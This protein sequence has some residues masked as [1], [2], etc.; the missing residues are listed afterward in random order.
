MIIEGYGIKIKDYGIYAD[1]HFGIEYV[2]ASQGIQIP[3]LQL[4]EIISRVSNSTAKKLI[5]AGDIKHE[6]G[7]ENPLEK[8]NVSKFIENMQE[9]FSEII[10][11]RGNHDNFVYY[12]LK[13]WGVDLIEYLEIDDTLIIHGH[14][15]PK[16]I[17]LKS[18]ET[19]V[20]GH[21]HPAIIVR[22]E[23]GTSFK[24]P[25]HAEVLHPEGYMIH[26][27]PAT[28]PLAL[29]TALNAIMGPEDF[30]SPILNSLEELNS[31]NVYA[32][33]ENTVERIGPLS[34]LREF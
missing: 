6:F 4:G 21:E 32:V 13:D 5:I 31:I 15:Y 26:V 19:I 30:L 29:G 23:F 11:V 25:V 20:M 8:R 22:D 18:Y 10:V 14:K 16:D 27:L 34:N 33:V 28:S 3:P 9:K 24:I 7:K 12:T 17:S 1:L 2:L